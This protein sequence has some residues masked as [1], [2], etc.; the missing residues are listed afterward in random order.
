M[1]GTGAEPRNPKPSRKAGSKKPWR[2]Y[3]ALLLALHML[4]SEAT[5]SSAL[6]LIFLLAPSPEK[7][8]RS[9]RGGKAGM[10]AMK[11]RL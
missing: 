2:F 9:F 3:K 10:R 4:E 5:P 8:L 11:A 6:A 1:P 7:S